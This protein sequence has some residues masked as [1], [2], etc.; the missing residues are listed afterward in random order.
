MFSM[1]IMP[2]M[3]KS[4]STVIFFHGGGWTNGS[5]DLFYPLCTALASRGIGCIT[6]DYRTA[7]SHETTPLHAVE[8]AKDAYTYVVNNAEQL[9]INGNSVFVAG[10]SAGGHLAAA[11]ITADYPEFGL[12]RHY[13]QGVILLG[14]VIDNS[15]TGYGHERVKYFGERFS[16]LQNLNEQF[17]R[18]LFLVGDK[19]RLVPLDTARE[20]VDRLTQLDVD[21]TLKVYAD[22]YHTFYQRQTVSSD[23]NGH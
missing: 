15:I 22:S 3:Q 1:M 18:T 14:P 11:I 17:P 20:F 21:A 2:P 16:P 5:A 19:D 8:D 12:S 9:G 4:S 7:K 13:P 10:H 23:C 6:A